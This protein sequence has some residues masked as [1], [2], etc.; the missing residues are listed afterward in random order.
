MMAA[1]GAWPLARAG[2]AEG[3]FLDVDSYKNVQRW[4][5]AVQ[6]RPAVQRGQR[7]NRVWG[8][9]ARQLPERHAASDL[10]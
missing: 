9:E 6:T 7:I 3:G 1:N 2:R 4:T 8:D 5:K 10:D